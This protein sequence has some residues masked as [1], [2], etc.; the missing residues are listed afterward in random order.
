L[1]LEAKRK[2]SEQAKKSAEELVTQKAKLEKEF[3]D[4]IKIKVEQGIAQEKRAFEK[5][6]AELKK[7]KNKMLQLEY[8]LKVSADKYEKANDEIKILKVQIEQG[9]TPQ[10]EGLLEEKRLLAKLKELFPRDKFEHPGKGGDIIQTVID[11]GLQIGKIVYECKK[12]KKFDNKHVA[13]AH[14]ARRQRNADF[15]ILVTN[16]FP[17]KKQHYFVENTVFVI[18]PVSLECIIYTLR[19]S[20][21]K[22]AV[23][24]I[25]NEAKEKAVQKVYEYLSSQEYNNKINDVAIH[26]LSLGKDLKAEIASHYRGWERR[27]SIYCALFNDVGTVDFELRG[28]I[29]DKLNGKSHLLLGPNKDYIEIEELA[30]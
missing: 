18:S 8:S 14:R 7:T 10:I 20:L 15:A 27:Y 21:L 17:Y 9:I 11:Q 1:E 25:S 28:L 29:Q 5:Q 3:N 2:I 19:E 23:L 4:R 16:A 13:Q 22:I 26:L 12:V 6:E 30:R 24:K